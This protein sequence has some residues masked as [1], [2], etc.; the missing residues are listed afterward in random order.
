MI[1][2]RRRVIK[3]RIEALQLERAAIA[4]EMKEASRQ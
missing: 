4:E 1:P 2:E 3:E